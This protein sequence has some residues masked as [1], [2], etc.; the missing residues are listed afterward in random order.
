MGP[1]AKTASPDEGA[2]WQGPPLGS[3]ATA[4][5]RYVAV[6]S[7]LA[8][9]PTAAAA[10]P[11]PLSAAALAG[12]LLSP[13]AAPVWGALATTWAAASLS[14]QP[15][16]TVLA[17]RCCGGA[18]SCCG[19]ARRAATPGATVSGGGGGGGGASELAAARTTIDRRCGRR[20][21]GRGGVGGG[22]LVYSW[23][24]RSSVVAASLQDTARG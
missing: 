1:Y 13:D 21:D 6:V 7:L 19:R 15:S 17:G 22:L 24:A 3:A 18:P 14:G 12:R 8:P 16:T 20:R 5:W 2:W 4:R 9:G 11:T 23:Y 10:A